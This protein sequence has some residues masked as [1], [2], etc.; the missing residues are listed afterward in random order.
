MPAHTRRPTEL[1]RQLQ[2]LLDHPLYARVVSMLA[3]EI[4]RRMRMQA[5]DARRY[6]LS[7]IGD[8][9]VLSEIYRVFV[10]VRDS[11]SAQGANELRVISRR[12]VVKLMRKDAIRPRHQSLSSWEVD[13]DGALRSLYTLGEGELQLRDRELREDLK[14]VL[15]RFADEGPT[16]SRQ[17]GLLRLV[18][19]GVPY[20]ELQA[21]LAIRSVN[22]ARV[23][24]QKAKDA[25]RKFI[26]LEWPGLRA[27]I[28]PEGG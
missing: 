28:A 1:E 3:K 11:D 22:A 9:E 13:L 25:L 10:H 12:H 23:R 18:L 17:A 20:E 21:R 16:Q 2:E 27:H 4:G 5:D 7:A 26:E 8:P 15:A 14:R 24:V 6:V 19:E